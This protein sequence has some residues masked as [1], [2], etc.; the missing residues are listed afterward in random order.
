MDIEK[1]RGAGTGRARFQY[2]GA[3]G[4]AVAGGGCGFER[5]G[6]C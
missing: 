2:R 4:T 3:E 6:W 5:C 1:T